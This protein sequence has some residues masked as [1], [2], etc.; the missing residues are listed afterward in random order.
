MVFCLPPVDEEKPCGKD[1]C[2]SLCVFLHRERVVYTFELCRLEQA[3]QPAEVERKDREDTKPNLPDTPFVAHSLVV[4]N[5]C[6]FVLDCRLPSETCD[7][8][9]AWQI[10]YNYTMHIA[11]STLCP[12]LT[13]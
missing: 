5:R 9:R 11:T 8:R 7:D 13:K 1:V 12:S 3:R 6:G 2:K 10:V 4:Q